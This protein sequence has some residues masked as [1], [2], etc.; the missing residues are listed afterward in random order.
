MLE[1]YPQISNILNTHM[2]TMKLSENPP[3]QVN[4]QNPLSAQLYKHTFQSN[5]AQKIDAIFVFTDAA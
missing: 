3:R 5:I 4:E 2:Q 1:L